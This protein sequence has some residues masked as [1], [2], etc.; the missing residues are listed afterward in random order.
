[1]VNFRSLAASLL[2]LS[3]AGIACAGPQASQPSKQRL[4]AI[5]NSVDARV[6]TQI[7]VWFDNGDYPMTIHLLQFQADYDS[8]NYDVV[9]NLGWMQENIQ[10][11]EDA[12]ATYEKYRSM[13]P[14]DKDRALAEADFLFR[15]HKYAPIPGLL[16][17]VIASRPHSNNYRIL[18][19]A[20]EKLNRYADALKVWQQL[21]KVD[22][23]DLPAKANLIK[24]QKKLA[25]QKKH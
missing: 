12:L 20:Y 8:S 15:R 3:C 7:N 23:S 24:V 10:E 21:V 14:K 18:A 2:V 16:E 1:M 17:P 22:P 6:D 5:W 13:N 11:W 4:D 25:A 9:T 19:H